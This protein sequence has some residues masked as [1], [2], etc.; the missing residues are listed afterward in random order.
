MGGIV[1]FGRESMK[2]MFL[3]NVL[4]VLGM[5]KN[6]VSVSMI[7]NRGFGVNVLDGKF[8]IFP[9]E[10]DPSAS[11]AVGVGCGKLYKLLFQPHHGLP[12]T[13]SNSELCEL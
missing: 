1:Y 6:L 13:Q 8:H 10:E 4:Y 7:V 9:K 2:P 5:K 11:Y 3:R 12:H